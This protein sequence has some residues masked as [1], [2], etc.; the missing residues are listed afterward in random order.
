MSACYQDF[1]ASKV[2]VRPPAGLTSRLPALPGRLFDWQARCVEWALRQGQAALFEDCGLGKTCQQLAWA[3]AVVRERNV[4]A[5]V[6]TPLAV[7]GQTVAEAAVFGIE[8]EVS[9]DG[10]A[11]R[12]ITVANYES[13]HKLN[14]GDFGAVVLDESSILKAYMGKTKQALF[15]AFGSTPFRLAATATPAPNDLLEL[16]N[17]AEFLGVLSSHEMIARWFLPDTSA[18]GTYRL[19]G[20]A[21][22]H[23]WRWVSSWAR[24]L[25]RP[26]DMGGSDEGYDLPPM[27][28]H[29]HLADVD[30]TEGRLDGQLFRQPEMSAAEIHSEK[31]RTVRARAERLAELVC[32]EPDE[33]WVLW[34]DTDYEADALQDALPDALEVRGS[35]PL[36]MKEERL[37][38]FTSGA[39]KV[40]ITKP[41]IAGFG[42]NWQHCARVG[43][44]GP[45]YSYE[46]FYQATRRC[47]RFGQKRPVQV[48]VVM[49]STEVDVWAVMMRKAAEHETM[50]SAMFQAM[51]S[52][53]IL[54]DNSAKGYDPRHIANLPEWVK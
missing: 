53:Q 10:K 28:V 5:L 23:Y 19:K 33:P 37:I 43:F 52:A 9:R 1:V 46:A 26:S 2:K 30:I 15:E 25:G 7:A 41:K 47:H 42:L 8:A 32:A 27:Q 51:R 29:Q 54:I 45:T 14:P 24:C 39:F 16:G 21:V 36:P 6:L 11:H 50:K 44:A 22:E 49:G 35:M 13:L 38:G 3:D 40:L 17:H 12:G 34:C 48:H 20:H 18:M 4:N 31:R